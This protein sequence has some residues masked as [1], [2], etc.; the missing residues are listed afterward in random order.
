MKNSWQKE[1]STPSSA[2]RAK[3]FWAW[4]GK[5]EEQ[6]LRRQV[7]LLGKMGFGGFFMHSRTGLATPYLSKEWF[8]LVNACIGEAAHCGMEAW[9]YDEDR[10]PSGAAGG[11]VTK[12]PKYSLHRLVMREI[13]RAKDF[14]WRPNTVAAFTGCIKGYTACRVRRLSRNRRPVLS[15]DDV[16]LEFCVLTEPGSDWFNG[17]PYLDTMSHA[18]VRRFIEVTHEAYRR[19]VGRDFGK[20][21][22]GIFTDEPHHGIRIVPAPW[23]N[24]YATPWTD[25]LPSVFRKRYGYDLLAYLPELFCDV[26]GREITPARYHYHDCVTHLFADAFARQIGEWCGRNRLAFTGHALAEDLLSSQAITA[27]SAMRFY[28]H[29]QLPGMDLLTEYGRIWDTAKQVS[30]AARQF[31]RKWRL[32]ETYGCTGWDFS[33]AGHKALGDWQAALGINVRCPHLSWYTMEGEAKR[34]YPASIFYQSAW[35]R[36]Y[37][38]IEDYFARIHAVMTRGEEVRDLL[39]IHPVESM[40]MLL[41]KGWDGWE[42]FGKVSKDSAERVREY[43]RMLERLRDSLLAENIDF[44]YGDEE[45]LARHGKVTIKNGRPSLRMAKATYKAVVVPPLINMRRST[46]TLL[47]RFHAAG[48]AVVFAGKIAGFV[49]A[50]PSDEIVAFAQKCRRA[51]AH[52]RA[53][54][55][56]VD[57]LCRRISIA[58]SD[59]REIVPALY[60]LREDSKAFYLFVCNTGLN[61]LKRKLK[62]VQDLPVRERT[63]S[64]PDVRIRGFAGCRGRPV[65]LDPETGR[66]FAAAAVLTNGQWEISTALPALGSRLFMIPRKSGAAEFPRLKKQKIVHTR[67]MG[68][69]AWD[70]ILSEDNNLVLDRPRYRIGNGAWQKPEE[71]LRV[72]RAVR[73]ALGLKPRGGAMIQPWARKKTLKQKSIPVWLEY[74]FNVENV[75]SGNIF[76]AVEKPETFKIQINGVPVNTDLECGWWVDRSLRKIPFE[77]AL[78]R[79]GRNTIALMGDYRE[80]H[81]GLEIIYLLGAFGTQVKGTDVTIVAKPSKLRLGNWVPQGLAFYSGSVS[82]VRRIRSAVQAGQRVV[83]H[84]PEYSGVAVKVWV[85]GREAGYAAW[86]PYQVDITPLLDNKNRQHELR[87][88]VLGHRR[89]SHGPLHHAN[90]HPVWTGPGEFVSKGKLWREDYQLVPCGLQKPPALLTFAAIGKH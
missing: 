45:L 65:E 72:D 17:Y 37:R 1:F 86:P 60:L 19:H 6:E 28:E 9:L 80:D 78:L 8:D 74:V 35:W 18:A 73:A 58:D 77:P 81:P 64:F 53:L 89:N 55:A 75:P 21:V 46:L 27:G 16:I 76:L 69:S 14:H 26:D 38:I 7:R 43:D 2:Y 10:W 67:P 23:A 71:V 79:P 48:G 50:K 31:G 84:V 56:A 22:P 41:R 44:D 88:E 82:Y 57:P 4:N 5:L 63:L 25:Q 47:Q 42:G 40:W 61:F 70:I 30:S 85:D 34:D 29:M 24:G 52:G 33:F 39:V 49:D 83:L 15:K 12:N 54:A 36:D 62:T 20:T 51:P 3:P 11:L 32:T 59:G 66:M 13:K 68:G 87:I 90:K